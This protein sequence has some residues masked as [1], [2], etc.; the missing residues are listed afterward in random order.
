MSMSYDPNRTLNSAT[1]PIA[2][3]VLAAF[4]H[5]PSCTADEG[6]PETWME[7]VFRLPDE[8]DPIVKYDMAPG[9][10]AQ[11]APFA[12][13]IVSWALLGS[14]D[15]TSWDL[16]H[17]KSNYTASAS[18]IYW[19]S[20]LSLAAG[21]VS[22]MTPNVNPDGFAIPAFKEDAVVPTVRSASVAAG[23]TL[24]SDDLVLAVDKLNFTPA[25]G[26]GTLSG[27]TLAETGTLNLTAVPS[28][29]DLAIPY[30][31]ADCAGVDNIAGWSVSVEGAVKPGW[32]IEKTPAG[33]RIVRPGLSMVF[34]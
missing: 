12:R 19:M 16:L 6:N 5:K 31:F 27:F 1:Q 24:A 34:K 30:V 28:N 14:A 18:Y 26:A 13:T 7:L 23:A 8:A 15:G 17:E 22:G 29:R 33:Y 2:Y 32:K 9:W 3:N 25:E 11:G 21:T 10:F 4:S 20:D